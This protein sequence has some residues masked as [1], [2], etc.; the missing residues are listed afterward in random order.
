MIDTLTFLTGILFAEARGEGLEG[1]LLVLGT[2]VERARSCDPDALR[3]V[4]SVPA[5]YATPDF[6]DTAKPVEVKAWQECVALVKGVCAGRI[7]P[8]AV[9]FSDGSFGQPTHFYNPDLCA[10]TP[11]W[12]IG[13]PWHKSG[14]H[15]FVRAE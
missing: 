8:P 4:A 10:E 7:V 11:A 1:R 15:V 14:N 3:R 12:A 6:P 9:Q 13:Q 2:M 5:H